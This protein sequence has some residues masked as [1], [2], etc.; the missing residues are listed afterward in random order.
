MIVIQLDLFNFLFCTSFIPF[1]PF[2]SL[3]NSIGLSDKIVFDRF[4][5]NFI[6]SSFNR[7]DYR[8]RQGYKLQSFI[9]IRIILVDESGN[10]F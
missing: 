1:S 2:L 10:F 5:I 8:T 3:C 4:I 6:V 9:A 7:F